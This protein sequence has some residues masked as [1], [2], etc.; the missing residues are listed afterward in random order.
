MC[1]CY[2]RRAIP[3]WAPYGVCLGT[4]ECETCDCE[5]DES[6]CDFYPEKRATVA[7]TQ[8]FNTAE[9]W[10]RAQNDGETYIEIDGLA[11]YSNAEGFKM[12]NLHVNNTM[13]LNDWLFKRWEMQERRKMTKEE[14]EKEFRIKIID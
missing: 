2:E 4:R 8:T 1:N 11:T 10:L 5:G 9:M 7:P 3:G 12:K 13:T 6:K 14:A